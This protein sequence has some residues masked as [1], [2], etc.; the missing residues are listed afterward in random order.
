MVE[1]VRPLV[2]AVDDDPA[3]LSALTRLLINEPYEFISTVDPDRALELVR[4]RDVS[5]L[6]ADYRMPQLSGTGLLQVVKATSPATIRVMLTAY[7]RSTWVLRAWEMELM[8]DVLEKPW[9]NDELR[10]AIR[11]RLFGTKEPAGS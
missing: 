2:V 1:A 9:D 8:E 6:L 3:V 5:L 4:T 7:P 11:S 10:E